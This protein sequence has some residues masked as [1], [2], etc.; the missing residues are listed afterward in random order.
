MH[1]IVIIFFNISL[2]KRVLGAQKKSLIET[3]LLS[4]HNIR[5]GWEMMF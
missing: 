5:F 1:N 4:T 2:L 3:L